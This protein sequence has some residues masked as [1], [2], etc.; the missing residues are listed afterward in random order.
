MGVE[1]NWLYLGFI[2]QVLTLLGIVL[3]AT[4]TQPPREEQWRPFLWTPALVRG[5]DAANTRWYASFWLWFSL[6]AAVWC[7]IYVW[8]W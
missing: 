8:L 7:A 1:L 3:V 2:A 4:M 5:Y 6:Y